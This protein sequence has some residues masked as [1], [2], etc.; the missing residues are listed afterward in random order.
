MHGILKIILL[1]VIGLF[2]YNFSFSQGI[3]RGKITDENGESAIGAGITRKSTMTLGAV[4]DLQGNY[5]F[6]VADSSKDTLIISW[7]GYDKMQ[8]P[9]HLVNG[10]VLIKNISF[11]LPT[12]NVMKEVEVIAKALKVKDNYMEKVK[13]NSSVTIDYVS[14]ETMKK[15]GDANVTAAVTRVAGVSTNQSGL[16]TVRG[17]GDR[18]IKTTINGSRIPTLDPFTNNIKLDMFPASL[19]DNVIITKTASPDLPGDWAG[20]YLS[21]ETKDYPEKFYLNVES[22]FG[23]NNSTTFR[24]VLSSQRSSTDWLGYDNGF[25]NI[26]QKSYSP[27]YSASTLEQGH[28]YLEMATALRLAGKGN[29]FQSLGVN[30]SSWNTTFFN[31]GLVQLGLL[32]NS[33]LGDQ[34]AINNAINIYNTSY[35]LQAFDALNAKTVAFGKSLPDNWL[36][37]TRSAP[38]DFSQSFSIG[39]QTKLF[40]RELGIIAGFRYGSSTRYDAAS[41]SYR[42]KIDTK[43][44]TMGLLSSIYQQNSIETNGW[45]A[46]V[47]L[48]YKLSSNHSISLLF[49]PNFIGVNNVRKG[50]A[51]SID[52]YGD[53]LIFQN[54]FYEQRKQMI[55]QFKSE[56][57]FPKPKLKVE[58]NASYT[59]GKSSAPDFKNLGYIRTPT[60][61]YTIGGGNPVQRFYRYLSEDLFDSYLVAELPLMNTVGL[62]RKLKFGGAYQNMIR[63]SDQYDYSINL[64]GTSKNFDGNVEQYLAPGN[65]GISSGT[66]NGIPYHALDLSYISSGRVWDH[67]IGRS[68]IA[69]GFAMLDYAIISSLRFSGGVRVEKA[70]IY[71]DAL[72]YDTLHY[73]PDDPRRNFL[74]PGVLGKVSYLP[75]AN[76][77]WKLKK[78]ADAPINL[79]FNYSQTV[80]RPSIRELSGYY[81]YDYEL[82]DYVAGNPNLKMVQ[83]N[84][85]DMRLESYFKSGD[86]VSLSLFYKDFKNHIEL[87][88][89]GGYTWQ[90]VDN[91]FVKG[92]E[93]EGKKMLFKKLELRANITFVNSRSEYDQ[94]GIQINDVGNVVQGTFQFHVK[95]SMYGQAPYVINT[96]LSYKADSIGLVT[97]IGYNLQGPKLI[98]PG[99]L[100]TPDVYE[101]PRHLLDAKITK[102]LGKYFSVSLTIRDILNASIRRTYRHDGQWL[103]DYD[104]YRYGTNYIATVSYTF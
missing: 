43:T 97:S 12:S 87:I 28:E 24:D 31:L 81:A 41:I 44:D 80:A 49:M 71:T 47:N 14:G 73:A 57:Y 50:I 38:L 96:I 59:F 100:E 23:Y 51:S 95:R 25:R 93:L 22:S 35:K 61:E 34:N 18:Y 26:D 45:S 76:L 91:S 82:R 40:K 54:Q 16:I 8:V 30:Q 62:I 53:T 104:K 92:I 32:Q 79:R 58:L 19:V 74:K 42:I 72:K 86:N 94:Y 55:Y 67:N 46:L 37:T 85:F 20:A 48:A 78:D 21:I 15:T 88:N 29:Y 83:I 52:E 17:I 65:F 64:T 99:F 63:Q 1:S 68:H 9:I 7:V 3:I 56:H 101:H 103:L 70:Y 66:F 13:I 89:A 90:N 69:S 84:N 5:S 102:R 10:E 33:Q 4:A 2:I 75:S 11:S 36:T 77:I 27:A 39:N 60:G 98:I 6:I